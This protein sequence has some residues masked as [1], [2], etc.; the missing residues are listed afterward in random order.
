MAEPIKTKFELND[1]TDPELVWPCDHCEALGSWPVCNDGATSS[2]CNH[3][4][5]AIMSYILTHNI[6]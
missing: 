2:A 5:F 6:D 1:L 4:A 3:C